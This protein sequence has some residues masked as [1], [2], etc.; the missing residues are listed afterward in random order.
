[1][2]C[3]S[4]DMRL[5]EPA[6]HVHRLERLHLVEELRRGLFAGPHL[7]DHRFAAVM[8]SAV[9]GGSGSS[10]IALDTRSRTS[11]A[12]FSLSK[13]R[14]TSAA[15]R[16]PIRAA[17][18]SPFCGSGVVDVD[19]VDVAAGAGGED[20]HHIVALHGRECFRRA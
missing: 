8:S 14:S 7:G 16:V 17:S 2:T 10:T 1:M 5:A 15:S 4:T 9:T 18:P 13:V 3:T 11:L 6:G 19:V 12:G 20:R